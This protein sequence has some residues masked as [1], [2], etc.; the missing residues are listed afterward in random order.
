MAP[1]TKNPRESKRA[2][3]AAGSTRRSNPASPSAT[4]Q[5]GAQ[6]NPRLRTQAGSRPRAQANPR[7]QAKGVQSRM[8][9]GVQDDS[10]IGSQYGGVAPAR[11]QQK[12]ESNRG[13]KAIGAAIVAVALLVAV[14]FVASSHFS[15]FSLFGQNTYRVALSEERVNS[16]LG[17]A[18]LTLPDLSGYQ[19]V[20][21]AAV[22]GPKYE[23]V[24]IGDVEE[25][26]DGTASRDVT[27]T[28]QY[29][30]KSLKISI[31]ISTTY[32]YNPDSE[33]WEMGEIVQG[34]AVV[35]PSAAPST[36]YF[37]G[38]LPALLD[39]YSS[40]MAAKYEG[41]QNDARSELTEEGGK[42]YVSLM[43]VDDRT[44]Y[45]CDLEID[46]TWEDGKGWVAAI[47]SAEEDKTTEARP[48]ASMKCS[49][50][51]TVTVSGVV[52]GT[53]GSRLTLNLDQET[54]LTIDGNRFDTKTLSLLVK[55]DD[56]GESILNKHVSV[57]GSI[58]GDL[59]TQSSPAGIAAASITVG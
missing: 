35:K 56:G 59:A 51:D 21:T 40:G 29:A 5:N 44:A 7:L 31:P 39:A 27:G 32:T 41:A 3:N 18:S 23:D 49:S 55:M 34:D 45:T 25:D 17:A 38:E 16:D 57:T 8:Q 37:T 26:A 48:P 46:V 13:A 52:S 42:L 4:E 43:K 1:Q 24:V 15:N 20:S 10:S 36:S 54:E 22:T 9:D 19:Y 53:A 50:G 11:A 6:G 2:G 30:N 12:Q 47:T 28:A 58:S 14:G 33:T